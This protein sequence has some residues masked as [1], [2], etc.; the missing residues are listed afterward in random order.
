MEDCCTY[1]RFRARSFFFAVP[2]IA[3]NMAVS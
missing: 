3:V 2:L 1:R